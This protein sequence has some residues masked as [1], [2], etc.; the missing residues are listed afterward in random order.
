M[1]ARPLLLAHRGAPAASIEENSMAAF[2]RA[3]D[4]G[5]DGFECDVRLTSSGQA[6]VCHNAKVAGVTVSR[7]K[8]TQLAHLPRIEEIIHRYGSRSF[9]DIELKVRGLEP[10]LLAALRKYPPLRD[11]L[12]SSF[13]PE[14]V[15]ELKARS[16]VVPVGIICGKPSQLMAWRNL[17]VE[18]VIVHHSLVTRRLVQLIQ[19]AGKKIVVWTVNDK[20]SMLRLAGWG[21]DAIISG[22]PE[23]LLKTLPPRMPEETC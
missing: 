19:G 2:D 17:P 4:Q 22:K 15:L 7:A 16:G 14:V 13:L 6:V 5:C 23:V 1:L 18:F 9:L 8:C 12:V 10:R 20:N 11:Y 3:L 21:V